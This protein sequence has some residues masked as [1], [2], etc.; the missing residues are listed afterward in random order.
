MWVKA[1]KQQYDPSMN[2]DQYNTL[3]R[4]FFVM[5]EGEQV[6]YFL[7]CPLLSSAVASICRTCLRVVPLGECGPRNE[8]IWCDAGHG[9]FI[10]GRHHPCQRGG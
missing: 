4:R 10:A 5:L 1:F 8:Q 6:P 7:C 2:K 9:A 3:N